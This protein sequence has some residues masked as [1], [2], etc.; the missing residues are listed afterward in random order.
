MRCTPPHQCFAPALQVVLI[1]TPDSAIVNRAV[2]SAVC[3]YRAV[4]R[5]DKVQGCTYVTLWYVSPSSVRRPNYRPKHVAENITIKYISR[6]KCSL[7]V[8]N[9][10]NPGSVFVYLEIWAVFDP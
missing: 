2:A 5:A 6:I 8:V 9:T 7:L 4:P 3:L 10:H 1:D